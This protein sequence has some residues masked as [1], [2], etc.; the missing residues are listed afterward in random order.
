MHQT[1]YYP[2]LSFLTIS[3]GYCLQST[4]LQ[5]V[6]YCGQSKTNQWKIQPLSKETIG[7]LWF[8]PLFSEKPNRGLYHRYLIAVNLLIA[9]TCAMIVTELSIKGRNRMAFENMSEYGLARVGIEFI[10]AVVLELTLEYYWHRMMHLPFFY[11]HLHKY[12]HHYKSPEPWD[13]LYIHPLE[14]CGYY[15]ILYC[16]PFVFGMHYSAFIAYMIVMGL[17][18]VIDHSGIHV[19]LPGLYN[20]ADH[21]RHHSKFDMNYGFPL[22]CFDILHGTYEGRFLGYSFTASPTRPLVAKKQP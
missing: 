10:C 18:G 9:S 16:P 2:L 7:T 3:V 6:F 5:Y 12:H 14:A 15:C 22:P 21:D 8:F 11:K 4:F 19:E 17:C 13:D 1:S 20:S